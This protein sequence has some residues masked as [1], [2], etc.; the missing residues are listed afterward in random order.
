MPQRCLDCEKVTLPTHDTGISATQC[1]HCQSINLEC[2]HPSSEYSKEKC[3]FVCSTC[4]HEDN[5]GLKT[6]RKFGEHYSKWSKQWQH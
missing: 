3:C 2:D 4:G 6:L 1:E 5:S